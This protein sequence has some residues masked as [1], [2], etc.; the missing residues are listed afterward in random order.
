MTEDLYVWKFPE[1]LVICSSLYRNN[2]AVMFITT[3][4]VEEMKYNQGIYIFFIYIMTQ[5]M[6]PFIR[7]VKLSCSV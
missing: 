4:L 2:R 6:N 3:K 1:K 7:S 5:N